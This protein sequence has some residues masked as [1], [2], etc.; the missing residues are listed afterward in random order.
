[1]AATT[2]ASSN[3][4]TAPTGPVMLASPPPGQADRSPLIREYKTALGE[5]GVVSFEQVVQAAFGRRSSPAAG[6]D[7]AIHARYYPRLL[8]SF[9][10]AH[11][12]PVRPSHSG[13]LRYYFAD[14]IDAAVIMT[15]DDQLYVHFK[16]T[17]ADEVR[18]LDL[19]IRMTGVHIKARHVLQKE[20]YRTIMET[21]FVVISYCMSSLDHPR[22]DRGRP[23]AR[24]ERSAAL[25][26]LQRECTRAEENLDNIIQRRAERTYFNGMLGAVLTLGLAGVVLANLLDRSGNFD[27]YK[28]LLVAAL[29][30]SIGATISVM[31]RITF[32][33]FSPSNAIIAF[34]QGKKASITL[35]ILG[36]VRPF[37]G[38]VF[39]IIVY[40]LNRAGLLPLAPP[41][42]G[43]D[44]LY[45]Y[46][47]IAF[48]AG[49]SERWAQST[50][51]NAMPLSGRGTSQSDTLPSPSP[52]EG[53][54]SR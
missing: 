52:P 53:Q 39:G 47:A 46:A 10:E 24:R 17:G 29:A 23:Q 51:K 9:A 33:R 11:K 48:F 22:S 27:N 4:E 30:G 54:V 18:F 13:I 8:Q 49:F 41:D 20:D 32:G 5:D 6:S 15:A 28:Y 34:Q 42:P 7:Q 3:G 12:C 40:A 16:P 31:W 14:H 26:Y 1:M 19:L 2:A 44:V 50:L 38:M 25:K 36:A 35:A 45:F 37:I 43:A 21:V